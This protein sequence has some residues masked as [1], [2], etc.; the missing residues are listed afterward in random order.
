MIGHLTPIHCP[1]TDTDRLIEDNDLRYA[2]FNDF[3]EL[4]LC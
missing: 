2:D 4:T 3:T 1:V